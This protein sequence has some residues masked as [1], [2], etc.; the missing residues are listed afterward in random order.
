M[1]SKVIPKSMIARTNCRIKD[2]IDE[3]LLLVGILLPK[4]RI[5]LVGT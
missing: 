5:L 4:A 1:R 2:A 3:D